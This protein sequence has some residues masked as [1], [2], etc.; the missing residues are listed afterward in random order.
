V[1]LAA[2]KLPISIMSR[3]L[4]DLGSLP[5]E[6]LIGPALGEDA[7]AI[8]LPGGV[9]VVTTDPVTLTGRDIGRYAVTVNANDLAVTGVRP[10]WFLVTVLLP[11]GATEPQVE[12]LFTDIQRSLVDSG[13]VLVGGH[14]EVTTAVNRP[15]L[16]GQMLGLAEDRRYVK[17]GDVRAGQVIVQV[18]RAPIEGAAVLAQEATPLLGHVDP[19]LRGAAEGALDTPG[20]SVVKAALLAVRLGC[21]AM[22][23][24]TEGGLAAGLHEMA[25]ASRVRLRVDRAR[26]L[27]WEPAL[28]LCRAVGADPWAT[29]ASGSLLAAFDA[30]E[31]GRVAGALA[32]AGHEAAVIAVAER[33]TGVID[34]DA[35]PIRWPDRD[36]LSRVLDDLR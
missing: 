19:G 36:E 8:D 6:I 27:W 13:A 17:T 22:H 28:A 21:T 35:E 29:L 31:T 24:P 4:A 23:D 7:Y 18:G 33:G 10:R 12:S 15:V 11:P 16:I 30:S 3:L 2:G 25:A 32:A 20:I 1:P 14:T 9:L 26:V 34:T 5:P